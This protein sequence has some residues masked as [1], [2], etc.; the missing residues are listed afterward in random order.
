MP[1]TKRANYKGKNRELVGKVMY[2]EVGD[3]KKMTAV[4]VLVAL[5]D[6]HST[7]L[8]TKDHLLVRSFKDSK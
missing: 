8:R 6:A 7:E 3:K 2:I 1:V 4:P 5:P